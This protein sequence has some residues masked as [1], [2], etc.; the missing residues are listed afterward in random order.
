VI[1]IQLNGDKIH[2]PL[3]IT[4]KGGKT[5]IQ[6]FEAGDK[7]L[8]IKVKEPP[9]DGKANAAVIELLSKTL[10]VPKRDLQIIRGEA[11]RIKHVSIQCDNSEILLNLLAKAIGSTVEACFTGLNP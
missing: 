7:W 6:P 3:R 8:R 10:S 11:S 9:E 1:S 4:P 5:A 2:L